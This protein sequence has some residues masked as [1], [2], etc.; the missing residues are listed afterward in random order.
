MN[1]RRCATKGC[2]RTPDRGWHLCPDHAQRLLDAA[3]GVPKV[4]ATIAELEMAAM[5]HG[6][7]G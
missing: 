1:R 6:A 4:Q 5:G 2:T 7:R 3:F